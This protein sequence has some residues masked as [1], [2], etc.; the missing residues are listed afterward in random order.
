MHNE[1]LLNYCSYCSTQLIVIYNTVTTVHTLAVSGHE[2]SSAVCLPT[3]KKASK[4]CVNVISDHLMKNVRTQKSP[5]IRIF[6]FPEVA[7]LTSV[8]SNS[9][10]DRAQEGVLSLLADQSSLGG[11][12]QP[13]WL[14]IN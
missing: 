13:R 6:R 12:A 4:C 5:V 9:V 14:N 8:S 7:F 10:T 1:S 3:V 11:T 2:L